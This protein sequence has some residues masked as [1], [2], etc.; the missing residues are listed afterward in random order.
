MCPVTGQELESLSIPDRNRVLKR[1]IDNWKSEHRMNNLTSE[2]SGSEEKLTTAVV[3]KLIN[4]ASDV[5]EKLGRARRLMAIGGVDFLLRKFQ[6]GEE[7]EKVQAAEHLLLCIRAEGGCR[8]YVAI[9][10]HSSSVLQLLH[11]EVLPARRTAVCLLTELLCLRRFSFLFNTCQTSFIYYLSTLLAYLLIANFIIFTE[12]KS[13]N[14][15]F[16]DWGHGRSSGQW[17]FYWSILEAWPSKNKPL[18]PFSCCNLMHWYA[19]F[20]F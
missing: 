12:G 15:C 14:R 3:S 1:L 13:L 16:V 8:N 7:D 18:L 20:K 4:S 10:I 9:K 2:N 11:S 6:Q 17:M 19:A 5:P